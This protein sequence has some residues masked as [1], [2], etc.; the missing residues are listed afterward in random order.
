MSLFFKSFPPLCV[1]NLDSYITLHSSS[2]IFSSAMSN[3]TLISFS[4]FLSWGII[5]FISRIYWDFISS[6]SLLNMYNLSSGFL[7]TWNTV[8]VIVLMLLP[9][10]YIICACPDHFNWLIFLFIWFVL[11]C[12]L[13]GWWYLI[14]YCNFTFL[15]T[16]FFYSY[17]YSWDLFWD[18]VKL[19]RNISISISIYFSKRSRE[20]FLWFWIERRGS[21]RRSYRKFDFSSILI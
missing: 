13:H 20:W 14:G 5:V 11:F 9:T 15:S 17:K 19:H 12:F 7:N 8:I 10:N 18:T 21:M 6:V 16:K 3:L 4:I 2:P 1:L